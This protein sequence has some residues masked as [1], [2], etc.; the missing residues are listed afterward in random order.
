LS[1]AVTVDL[2][3][4]VADLAVTGLVLGIGVFSSANSVSNYGDRGDHAELISG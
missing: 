3:G 1:A 4:L 2:P